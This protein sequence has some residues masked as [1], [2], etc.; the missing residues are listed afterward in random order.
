MSLNKQIRQILIDNSGG[1]KMTKLVTLLSKN[2]VPK[3]I[4]QD[5]S[6]SFVNDIYGE[7]EKMDDVKILEYSDNFGG[8]RLKDFV[9]IKV[10]EWE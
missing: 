9:Y 2:N 7:I 10:T 4:L 8:N 6:S 5:L 1:V 3:T